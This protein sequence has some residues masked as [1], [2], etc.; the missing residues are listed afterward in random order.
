MS[1]QTRKQRLARIHIVAKSVGLEGQKYRSWL[2]RRTGKTSC[3]DLT[4]AQ[5]DALAD[6]LKGT[7]SQWQKLSHLCKTMGWTGFE[8]PGFLTF[9]KRTTGEDEPRL[10]SRP[11]LS[12]LIVGLEKWIENLRQRGDLPTAPGDHA[13]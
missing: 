10:L 6:D 2:E 1:A 9:V 13:A 7:R 5:L 8:D 3:S 11:E 4:D 12:N